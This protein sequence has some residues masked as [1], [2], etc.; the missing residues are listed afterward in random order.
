M[1]MAIG[2]NF[3]CHLSEEIGRY[4]EDKGIAVERYGALA[5]E[6]ADYVD[7][8]REVAEAVASGD[9]DEGV[10]FCTTGTGVSIVANKVPGIRAALCMDPF[11]ARIARLAN[12]ANV[13]VLGIRLTGEEHAKEI[14][15]AW[16]ETDPASAEPHRVVFHRKVDEVEKK[17]Q[18]KP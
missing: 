2:S 9:Y 18:R 12:N 3:S 15:D 14:V 13:L 16:L 1:K 7:A 17:Y 8:A 11:S 5:G 6:E 10:L 4:L